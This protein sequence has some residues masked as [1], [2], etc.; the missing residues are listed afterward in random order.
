[1]LY[2]LVRDS[3][4][5]ET[6]WVGSANHNSIVVNRKYL[7]ASA[8]EFSPKLLAPKTSIHHPHTTQPTLRQTPCSTILLTLPVRLPTAALHKTP[9]ATYTSV[10]LNPLR[11]HPTFAI[12]ST[13]KTKLKSKNNL[14]ITT[15]VGDL[16]SFTAR[17]AATP[18]TEANSLA[19]GWRT[20][21]HNPMS[22][23]SKTSSLEEDGE[24]NRFG[25][26]ES[27]G[28]GA[29]RVR[30]EDLDIS[31]VS[32]RSERAARCDWTFSTARSNVSLDPGRRWP[33]VGAL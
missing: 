21:D 15:N 29:A 12:A 1:M 31:M 23:K 17:K 11:L 3:G 16:F 26:V 6:G 30:I 20:S 9:R 2:A 13:A 4:Q 5:E 14:L 33:C 22:S 10:L 25:E 24:P 18:R 7:R 32:R 8:Q 28:E 27:L 19:S